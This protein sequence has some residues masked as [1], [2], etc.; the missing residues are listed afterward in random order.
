MAGAGRLLGWAGVDYRIRY[1]HKGLP[2]RDRR[3]A[4][5]DD[6]GGALFGQADHQ[7]E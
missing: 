7:A 4:A 5:A 6:G 1:H 2:E 3:S